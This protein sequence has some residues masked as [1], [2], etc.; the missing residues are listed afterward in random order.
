[1]YIDIIKVYDRYE[2][3]HYGFAV[4]IRG[5]RIGDSVS[6]LLSS[7]FISPFH[8]IWIM[9][10]QLNNFSYATLRMHFLGSSWD[11]F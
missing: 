5:I 2:C 9:L 1:M 7:G 8:P 11:A 3:R 6:V 4:S 10:C